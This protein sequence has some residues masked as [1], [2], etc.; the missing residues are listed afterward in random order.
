MKPAALLLVMLAACSGGGDVQVT[1]SVTFVGTS[2]GGVRC[3]AGTGVGITVRDGDG[4][5]IGTSHTG[6]LASPSIGPMIGQGILAQGPC[7]QTAPFALTLPQAEFY[8]VQLG[9][10]DPL[11]PISYEDLK[12]QGFRLDLSL[13]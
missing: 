2:Y 3:F 5:V 4:S 8:V 10:T 7:E 12:A 9:K 11:E 13:S 1:G 6:S